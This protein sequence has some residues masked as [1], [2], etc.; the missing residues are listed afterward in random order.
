VYNA[1]AATNDRWMSPEDPGNGKVQR[2]FTS[3]ANTGGNT[4]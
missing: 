2:A 4:Q 3:S 1:Y